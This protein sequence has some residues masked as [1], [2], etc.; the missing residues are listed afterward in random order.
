MAKNIRI[1]SASGDILSYYIDDSAS[2]LLT[3]YSSTKLLK[4]LIDQPIIRPRFRFHWLNSDETVKAIIPEEDI[5]LGGSYQEN[6]QNGQRRSLSFSLHNETKRY[7]PN[8]NG[9][10]TGTKFSFDMGLELENGIVIWFP[11]GVYSV[12]NANISHS[13]G[14]KQVDVELGDKFSDLEGASGTLE[15]TYTIPPGMVIEEVIRDILYSSKGNGDMLDPIPF[16]YDS[17]FKGRVTQQTISEQAG[18]TYGAILLQLATQLSAE[19]FYD[20]EGHLNIVPINNVTNDADKPIIYHFYEDKG[21]FGS[22]NLSFN[23][24]EIINRVVVIGATINSEVRDATAVNDDTASPLCYQRIGYRTAAPI[25]DNNITSTLLAQ[26]R[27]DYEL[28]NKL[29]LKSS[30]SNDVRFNPLLLVNNLVTVTDEYYGFE[31]EKFLL[32]SISCPIDYSGSMS[33]T[34]ANARNLPFIVGG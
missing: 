24:S 15:T 23:L 28:R 13:V 14:V 27:A 29:I 30:A 6:Y 22:N 12:T 33:I 11:K 3:L 2:S 4:E 10:W 34:S 25:N 21:D 26:E 32:Q 9:I 31:Q 20:V 8:I 5:I 16:I 18:S 7:T 1:K 19:I 17:S